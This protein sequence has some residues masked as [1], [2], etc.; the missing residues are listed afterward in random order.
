MTT[1]WDHRLKRIDVLGDDVCGDAGSFS[2]SIDKFSIFILL[3]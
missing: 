3:R 1:V 2:P